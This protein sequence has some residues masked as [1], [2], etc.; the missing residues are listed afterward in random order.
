M[1]DRRLRV[2]PTPERDRFDH[3]GCFLAIV[4][5]AASAAVVV[6]LIW[7]VVT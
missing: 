2:V 3:L 4:A 7:R 6:W 1:S 5:L